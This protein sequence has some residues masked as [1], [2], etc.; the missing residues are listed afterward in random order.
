VRS[1]RK[2]LTQLRLANL[3]VNCASS[4]GLHR[5]SCSNETVRYSPKHENRVQW[6][7]SGVFVA[8]NSDTTL[9]SEL[10]HLWHQFDKFCI[11]FRV[12]T[13]EWIRCVRCEKF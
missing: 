9:C 4:A 7:G 3:G 10:A 13:I 12:V 8:K 2:I 5:L 6:S 1:L 11:D